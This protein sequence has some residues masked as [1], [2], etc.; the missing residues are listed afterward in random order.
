[1]FLP[2]LPLLA[3]VTSTPLWGLEWALRWDLGA[4][5]NAL[6]SRQGAREG[7]A[8]LLGGLISFEL[9]FCESALLC[10]ALSLALKERISFSAPRGPFFASHS[11][12]FP[13]CDQESEKEMARR[14]LEKPT[15]TLSF[16]NEG[17]VTLVM[18]L[19]HSFPLPLRLTLSA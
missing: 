19:N 16:C 13:F 3:A 18:K 17:R 2:V 15:D 14:A 10:L 5:S 9:L 6:C 7:L 8:Q 1:M 11:A 12:F 4:T